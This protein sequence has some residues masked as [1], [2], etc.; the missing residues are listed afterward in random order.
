[1]CLDFPFGESEK[2]KKPQTVGRFSR[3]CGFFLGFLSRKGGYEL[4]A[5]APYKDFASRFVIHIFHRIGRLAED[6]G[7]NAESINNIDAGANLTPRFLC[8]PL[9]IL[10]NPCL[11]SQA[12]VLFGLIQHFAR[13]AHTFQ[14]LR[15]AAI[16]ANHMDDRSQFFACDAVVDCATA[17]QFPFCHFAKRANHAEIHH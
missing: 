3:F 1:V 17:M 16:N 10:A 12:D 7:F 6:H 13:C 14:R 11:F 15:H 2:C 5:D 9:L 4:V 8:Q